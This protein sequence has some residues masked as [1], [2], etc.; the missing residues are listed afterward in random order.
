MSIQHQKTYTCKC[1]RKLVLPRYPGS[2]TCGCG[3]LHTFSPNLKVTITDK[4]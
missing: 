4:K 3:R 2:K 1:K